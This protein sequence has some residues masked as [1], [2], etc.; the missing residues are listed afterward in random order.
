MNKKRLAVVSGSTGRLGRATIEG[1]RN[2]GYRV[3]GL[4]RTLSDV[5]W[6][7][8]KMD[9]TIDDDVIHAFETLVANYGSPDVV[10]HTVG[11]WA[12]S[13]L[14]ETDFSAWNA[15][16]ALNLNSSFLVFREAV[17]SFLSENIAGTQNS[18]AL[19]GIASRQGVV[20]GASQQAGYS[21]SKGGLVRLVESVDDELRDSGVRAYALAPSTILFGEEGRGIQASDL[22]AKCIHLAADEKGEKAGSVVEAYGTA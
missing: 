20:H 4:D 12:M 11:T 19:I 7:L 1:F 5:D 2:Q 13:P 8:I 9:A 17:R 22:V 15:L 10:I 3:V 14:V 16:I 6:P 18:I 21:A